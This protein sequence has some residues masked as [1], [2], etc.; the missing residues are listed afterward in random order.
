M[1][2]AAFDALRERARRERDLDH[3]TPRHR[4]GRGRAVPPGERTPARL[5]HFAGRGGPLGIARRGRDAIRGRRDAGARGDARSRAPAPRSGRA[6]ISGATGRRA[7]SPR[8]LESPEPPTSTGV[9]RAAVDR[10]APRRGTPV[11]AR[12]GARRESASNRWRSRGAFFG[13]GFPVPI[14]SSRYTWRESAHTTSP[15]RAA[16]SASPSA[17]LP[18]AVA[19]TSA[20][21]RRSLMADP[22]GNV[23]LARRRA[24]RRR[25]GVR[26]RA[27]PP[28]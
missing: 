24:A 22:S 17:V 2:R 18:V 8:R 7:P 11:G 23:H 16:A 19:P 10:R 9:H 15:P 12:A 6:R 4:G 13:E 26:K 5:Q 14:S 25:H 3:A 21:T 28:A 27:G 20:T 1:S